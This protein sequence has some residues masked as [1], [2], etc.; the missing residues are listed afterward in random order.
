MYTTYNELGQA[1]RGQKMNA[2]Q[3]PDESDFDFRAIN[4]DKLIV[5][6]YNDVGESVEVILSPWV[7]EKP[8]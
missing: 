4:T 6:I 8:A 1:V 7:V 3:I 5:E 2:R